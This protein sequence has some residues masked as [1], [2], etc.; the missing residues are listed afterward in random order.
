M[1]PIGSI[2]C[3]P[4]PAIDLSLPL[5]LSGLPRTFQSLLCSG[6]VRR[7]P[8][9]RSSRSSLPSPSSVASVLLCL[10]CGSYVCANSR[11]KCH[12]LHVGTCE[13]DRGCFLSLKRGDCVIIRLDQQQASSPTAVVAAG[14]AHDALSA[15]GSRSASPAPPDTT[16]GPAAVTGSAAPRASQASASSTASALS[17]FSPSPCVSM[18]TYSYCNWPSLY[19]DAY[20]ESDLN[21]VRGRPLYLNGTRQQALLALLTQHGGWE[22]HIQAAMAA[23][24]LQQQQQQQH[25]HH[26]QQQQMRMQ[27]QQQQQQMRRDAAADG[28]RQDLT[29][30]LHDRL[31]VLQAAL[32]RSGDRRRH[33]RGDRERSRR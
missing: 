33:G 8:H 21:L 13:G 19:L 29:Q 7:C 18:S 20:G 5:F 9:C 10:L 6:P 11:N 15:D 17:A 30:L 24:R 26:T 3:L 12:L 31:L 25:H 27:Q 4:C 23:Q 16:A 28:A 14:D 1:F 2:R 22:E 32:E